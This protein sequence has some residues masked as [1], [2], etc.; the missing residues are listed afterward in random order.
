M[1]WGKKNQIKNKFIGVKYVDWYFN[2]FAIIFIIVL[3]FKPNIKKTTVTKIDED[4]NEIKEY[5]TTKET[6]AAGCA[7]KIIVFPILAIIIIIIIVL[8]RYLK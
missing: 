7:A 8:I 3:A 4:G 1:G 2:C 5:H 6:S